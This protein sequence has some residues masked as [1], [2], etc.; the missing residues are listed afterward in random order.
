MVTVCTMRTLVLISE[1]CAWNG[2]GSSPLSSMGALSLDVPW[3]NPESTTV[4]LPPVIYSRTCGFQIKFWAW[5]GK[6]KVWCICWLKCFNCIHTHK[7]TWIYITNQK[8]T[9]LFW[10][11]AENI[12]IPRSCTKSSDH[13]STLSNF[14]TP[15]QV[16]LQSHVAPWQLRVELSIEG[17]DTCQSQGF[18]MAS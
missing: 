18:W 2:L 13:T 10:D 3:K 1:A 12:N 4:E 5:L 15:S 11:M 8:L 9:V 16:G 17:G 14:V 6:I 7:Q